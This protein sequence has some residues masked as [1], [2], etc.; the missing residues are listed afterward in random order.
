LFWG[1]GSR[2]WGELL[3]KKCA[4]WK[5]AWRNRHAHGHL[6]RFRNC[7]YCRLGRQM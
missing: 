6:I 3:L 4:A 7:A 5:R 1:P 2:G